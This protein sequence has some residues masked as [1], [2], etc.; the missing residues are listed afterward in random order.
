MNSLESLSQYSQIVADTGD[1]A[2]IAHWQ[3]IDCTTNPSLILRAISSGSYAALMQQAISS[4]R[5]RG[6]AHVNAIARQLLV[7]FAQ[8]ISQHIDGFISCELDACLS[9][10]T[11]AMVA[12]AKQLIAWLEQA[13]VPQQRVLIKIAATWEGIRACE[14]LK[15]A[16]I[17]CNMT[18]IFHLT[19]AVAAAQA[20]AYLISPFVGRILDWYQQRSEQPISLDDDPGVASVRQIYNHLKQ[21]GYTTLVMAA[22]F[23]NTGQILR[24]AGCDKLTISP[25]LL[26]Q[27][28]Q[29]QQSVS[30]QLQPTTSNQQEASISEATFRWQLNESTMASDKLAAGIRQFHTDGDKLKQ[31]IAAQLV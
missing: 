26:A 31:L 3:P 17:E 2:Q 21:H 13:G 23:R 24:L 7:N 9:F 30:R 20:G 15:T 12:E 6:E 28:Q 27:L 18:L 19:Q 22:S 8:E 14:Q 1:I 10:D 29:Q 5:Q 11:A 4:V 16:G 25:N